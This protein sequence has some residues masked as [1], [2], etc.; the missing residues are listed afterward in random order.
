MDVNFSKNFFR[1]CRAIPVKMQEADKRKHIAWSFWLTLFSL[2]FLT[3]YEAFIAVFLVGLFKECGDQLFGSGFCLYDMTGNVL[4]S[5][6][7]LGLMSF[8]SG[9]YYYFW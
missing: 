5:T 3:S 1:Y 9:C 8:I 2:S 7:A 6:I 4:G